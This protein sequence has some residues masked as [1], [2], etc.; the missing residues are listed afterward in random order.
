MK[1]V[2][3][4]QPRYSDAMPPPNDIVDI[5]GRRALI[6]ARLT[7]LLKEAHATATLEDIK[8][9]IYSE[10]PDQRPSAYFSFLFSMFDTPRSSLEIGTLAQI[11][12]DAWNYCPHRCLNGQC[13]AEVFARKAAP[14]AKP[15]RRRKSAVV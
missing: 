12:Q 7:A 2:S 3:S 11:V 9:V 5:L 4:K 15:K 13:P 1:I 6:E 8:N 14:P 10:D